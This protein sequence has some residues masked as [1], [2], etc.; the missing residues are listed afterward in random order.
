MSDI[1]GT[2]TIKCPLCGKERDITWDEFNAALLSQCQESI[3]DV[4]FG[5]D[6]CNG[7]ATRRC[8]EESRVVDASRVIVPNM[9]NTEE[10]S[11]FSVLVDIW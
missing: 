4:S 1:I 11:V 8:F 5:C 7:K 2:V 10:K 3:L 6:T 9:D